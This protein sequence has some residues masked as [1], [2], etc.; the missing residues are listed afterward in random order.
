MVW[1]ALVGFLVIVELFITF[2]GAG[3]Q[4]DPR[5]ELF[6]PPAILIVGLAGLAGI[7]LSHRTG[8]PPAWDPSVPARWRFVYPSLIGIAIGL[9]L[10]VADNFLHWTATF[11]SP[12]GGPFNA[13]FP[14]S[15]VFYPGGAIIVEVFY[16]L[17]PIPLVIFVVSNLALGGRWQEQVFWV[18]AALTSL[19][20]P[21]SQDLPD[22]R[23][24]TELA[25]GLN[26]VGDYA[27]NFFQA[28]MFRRYGYLASI[29]LRV[30]TYLVWHVAYGNFLCRC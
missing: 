17:L 18:L 2:V 25:V 28:V 6:S 7:W 13:P 27:L 22:L 12:G 1:L 15:L 14:G 24:G 21:A 9:F 5:A 10:S 30:A 20:E 29:I 26:F 16:R 19:I 23:A 8:F 4:N 3:L 11:S